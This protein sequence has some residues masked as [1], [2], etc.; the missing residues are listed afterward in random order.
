M[1]PWQ[2]F[3]L[4]WSKYYSMLANMVYSCNIFSAL[5]EV[6]FAKKHTTLSSKNECLQYIGVLI[7]LSIIQNPFFK[8]LFRRP[9]EYLAIWRVKKSYRFI[10]GLE[11][12]NIISII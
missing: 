7:R 4:R 8:R 10:L 12:K 5:T 3:R 9:G 2:D 1:H 11:I 6:L